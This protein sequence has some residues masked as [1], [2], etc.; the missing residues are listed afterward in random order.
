VLLV[1]LCVYVYV[2]ISYICLCVCLCA[3]VRMCG[4]TGPILPT[5]LDTVLSKI[6]QNKANRQAAKLIIDVS[7]FDAAAMKSLI[8]YMYTDTL[9]ESLRSLNDTQ[10]VCA[11]KIHHTHIT[12]TSHTSRIHYTQHHTHIT[13]TSHTHHTYI[14][15]TITYTSHTYH[16]YITHTSH[17]H[18]ELVMDYYCHSD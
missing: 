12:H 8:E 16:T 6:Q 7:E 9:T 11:W 14:I 17:T 3:Y 15:H 13:H 10:I 4:C 1:Y 5:G 18:D 2:L